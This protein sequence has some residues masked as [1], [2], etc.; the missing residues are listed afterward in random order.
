MTSHLRP[1]AAW[2]LGTDRKCT[3]FAPEMS[4][5]MSPEDTALFVRIFRQ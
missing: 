1:E 3:A 5:M 4:E 2:V